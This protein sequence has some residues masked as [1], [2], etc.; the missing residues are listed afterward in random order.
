M[1][2]EKTEKATP[3]R[4]QDERKKGNV[5]QS[6]E[7]LAVASLLIMF[8]LIKLL[9]PFIVTTLMG[10]IQKMFSSIAKEGTLIVKSD[11][12]NMG[13]DALIIIALVSGPMLFASG[14][15]AIL[16]T[17]AQTKMLV[18]FESI[19]F[20][21]S[22]LNPI[23][24]FKRMFSLRG[25]VELLKSIIKIVALVIIIYNSVKKKISALPRLFDMEIIPC[26]MFLSDLVFSIINTA[27]AIFVFLAIG[28]YIYQWWDYEKNLR[29]SKD[30]I[31]E[32][33]KQME[34]DPQ[35]KGKIK[36]KQRQMAQSRMM[37]AVPTADVI[38]RNPTHFAVALKY[39]G[40]NSQ[41]P[42][43]VAKGQDEI[44][45][46]IVE[47]AEANG[48]TVM[49]NV[50]L[51]R[52]LYAAVDIDMEIPEQFYQPVAEVLAFVYNLKNKKNVIGDE[53]IK[54]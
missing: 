9:M 37:Q 7:I 44:A 35:V 32:E 48:V 41:A 12:F 31:K 3:K 54:R 1:A 28:D 47:I 18:T 50:A 45:L 8:N 22:K 24:G 13:M 51:A 14:L 40:E 15:I 23:N 38:I 19:K 21:F 52:G 11:M 17:F 33:Y 34:G 53:I 49:E 29:M 4:K 39:D 5:F 27:G 30:E 36:E 20:K 16:T 25:V 42:K 10:Y 46:K 43:V 2:G 6:S 26:V